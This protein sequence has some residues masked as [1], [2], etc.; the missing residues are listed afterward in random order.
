VKNV[1]HLR[2]YPHLQTLDLHDNVIEDLRPLEALPYVTA[3]NASSNKLKGCLQY[4]PPRCNADTRWNSGDAALGSLLRDAD[5][6]SNEI[7]E[8]ESVAHH[9]YL[10]SLILDDN[11]ISSIGGVAGLKFLKTLCISNNKL[12]AISGLDDLPLER[13]DLSGNAIQKLENLEKLPSLMIL[14]VAN[15]QI[16][17]LQG[18]EKLEKLQI[19]NVGGNQVKS[20][21]EVENLTVN[22]YLR[23]LSLSG[24]PVAADEDEQ[25]GGPP[26]AQFYRR[27]VL[28]R[29][30]KL[31]MLDEKL[32][33]AEEKVSALNLHAIEGSVEQGLGSDLK[34]RAEVSAKHF[35][36][37]GTTF[38]DMLPPF[39]E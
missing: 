12:G 13:L 38:V 34:N 25:F 39:S 30:T 31:S 7:A 32:V 35:D 28:V 2:N 4:F 17:T 27:R 22:D 21:L 8:L 10:Q 33:T 19:L 3:L 29:L 1:E 20:I 18:L 23:E 26:P 6:S 24:N 14:N 5:L 37:T 9:T 15:N 36:G 16:E 11:V